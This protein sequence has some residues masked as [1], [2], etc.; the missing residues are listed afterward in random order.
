MGR[1]HSP[2]GWSEQHRE[3]PSAKAELPH[4][5]PEGRGRDACATIAFNVT[6]DQIDSGGMDAPP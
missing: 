3:A 6:T 2:V 1:F 5:L 4:M